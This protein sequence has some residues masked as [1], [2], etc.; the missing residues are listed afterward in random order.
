MAMKLKNIFIVLIVVI[1]FSFGILESIKANKLSEVQTVKSVNQTKIQKL[2]EAL[3][4]GVA[5]VRKVSHFK[6][7]V[8][9][10]LIF[11]L[12]CGTGALVEYIQMHPDAKARSTEPLEIKFFTR[13]FGKGKMLINRFN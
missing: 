9:I 8:I 2:P 5:K 4:I 11:M 13:Y 3:I 12:K 7:Y 6:Y 1:L 10:K